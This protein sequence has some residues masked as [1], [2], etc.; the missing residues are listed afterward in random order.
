[1]QQTHTRHNLRKQ[2]ALPLIEMAAIIMAVVALIFFAAHRSENAIYLRNTAR[3]SQEL[4]RICGLEHKY[5]LAHEKFGYAEDIGFSEKYPFSGIV[6]S[7]NVDSVGFTA[8]AR[9]AMG[10]DA[11]GDNRPGNEY[12]SVDV[13]DNIVYQ[14]FPPE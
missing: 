7:I 2:S 3:V 12:Y 1:M 9:E 6:Y 8:F 11:F 4:H 14:T 5:F 10:H 13:M